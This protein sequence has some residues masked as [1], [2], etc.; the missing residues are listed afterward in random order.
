M[1]VKLLMKALIIICNNPFGPGLYSGRNP[2]ISVAQTIKVLGYFSF[3]P[4]KI[5]SSCDSAISTTFSTFITQGDKKTENCNTAEFFMASAW[6]RPKHFCPYF[7]GQNY[8]VVQSKCKG[9]IVLAPSCS[10]RRVG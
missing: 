3:L 5:L 10:E 9:C 2:K 4:T 1:I 8:S 6:M 7:F